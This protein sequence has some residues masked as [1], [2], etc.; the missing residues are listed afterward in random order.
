[1]KIFCSHC[2]VEVNERDILG[3][4]TFDPNIGKYA[5]TTFV[6]FECPSCHRKEY[7]L[8]SQNPFP[9][10]RVGDVSAHPELTQEEVILTQR[11]P[12]ITT[13]D[14]I[15]FYGH[16]EKVN[17]VKEFL[18]LCSVHRKVMVED[19]GQTIARPRDVY[20]LFVKYNSLEQQRMMVLL[21]DEDNNLVTWDTLGDGSKE[22]ISF[23]PRNIF[24]TPL[25][26]KNDA[27]I[28]LAHCI[29]TIK[30]HPEKK[31]ILRIKRLVKAGRILGIDIIDYIVIH[32]GG[33][34]SFD[35]LN[36]L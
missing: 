13:N 11:E 8:L 22:E 15:D 28:I 36:L 32:K 34:Y 29:E 23:E 6:T 16:I 35:Q 14:L 17:T 2:G 1:M 10:S 3:V 12:T 9:K 31:D 19:Q 30:S 27:A 5:G 7:Q 24:R 26:L 21:I 33:Y 4:G 20:N 25:M 18:T